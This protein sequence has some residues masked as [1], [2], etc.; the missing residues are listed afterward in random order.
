LSGKEGINNV[1]DGLWKVQSFRGPFDRERK[2][3]KLL[4]EE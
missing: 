3:L 1:N 2:L 4:R